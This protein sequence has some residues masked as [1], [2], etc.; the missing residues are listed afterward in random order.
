VGR[1]RQRISVVDTVGKG[2]DGT[3]GTL[4]PGLPGS[5]LGSGVAGRVLPVPGGRAVA[6][7]SPARSSAAGRLT[8][9][10][11]RFPLIVLR[12]PLV[13]FCLSL[14][15]VVCRRQRTASGHGADGLSSGVSG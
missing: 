2:R 1:Q 6:C 11:L 13:A 15:L 4:K 3:G 12:F 14:P 9:I 5:P 8:L 10:V 7:R